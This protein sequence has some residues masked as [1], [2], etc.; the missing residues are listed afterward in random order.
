VDIIV[1]LVLLFIL[2]GHKLPSLMRSGGRRVLVVTQ[3]LPATERNS[4]IFAYL[5]LQLL[6]VALVVLAAGAR[7]YQ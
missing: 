7:A 4:A 5:M 2:F 1:V 6:L 3:H